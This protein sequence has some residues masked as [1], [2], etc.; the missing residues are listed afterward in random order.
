MPESLRGRVEAAMRAR[1]ADGELYR[2]EPI[3]QRVIAADLTEVAFT[4][5]E[6]SRPCVKCGKGIGPSKVARGYV[7]CYGCSRPK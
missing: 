1:L 4:A 5:M 3:D 7:L 2:L 6:G